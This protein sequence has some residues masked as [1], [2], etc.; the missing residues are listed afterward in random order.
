LNAT[1]AFDWSGMNVPTLPD[2]EIG[3]KPIFLSSV[4]VSAFACS[5]PKNELTCTTIAASPASSAAP[6]SS[7]FAVLMSLL[8]SPSSISALYFLIASTTTGSL[9]VASPLLTFSQKPPFAASASCTC[10]HHWV[11]HRSAA[12]S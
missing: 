1:S 3:K 10:T 9:K 4:A 5:C 8:N 6:W 11:A 12:I 7:N 2:G